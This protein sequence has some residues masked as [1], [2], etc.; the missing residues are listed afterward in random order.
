MCT[1]IKLTIM[2][3]VID[4]NVKKGF[5]CLCINF[6]YTIFFF[7]LCIDTVTVT[8]QTLMIPNLAVKVIITVG[9]IIKSRQTVKRHFKKSLTT[10]EL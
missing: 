8:P 2:M 3:I 7:F 5:R 10:E 6:L 4:N 1:L 9:I